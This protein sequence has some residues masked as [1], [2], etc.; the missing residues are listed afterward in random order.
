MGC[1]FK[2]AVTSVR[3]AGAVSLGQTVKVSAVLEHCSVTS[4]RSDMQAGQTVLK[5][6]CRLSSVS[7]ERTNGC[8]YK[9]TSTRMC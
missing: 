4:P 6:S 2:A 3:L 9:V 1:L 8:S 7:N 5:R